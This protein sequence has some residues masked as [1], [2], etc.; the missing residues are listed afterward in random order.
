MV[1]QINRA[2]II[3]KIKNT[4]AKDAARYIAKSLHEKKI[5][6]FSLE[7]LDV[8]NIY[9][10]EPAELMNTD[11][12]LVFGTTLRAFRMVRKS[13]PVF[14][15][16][17]GGTRGIL[18]EANTKPIEQQLHDIFNENY[19][20]DKRLR[21]QAHVDGK[22]IG[23]AL[24]DVVITRTNLTK[25]PIFTINVFDYPVSQ[26]MDGVI[27]STPTGSTGH[28]L[29]LGGPIVHENMNCVMILP[30]APVNKT[31]ALI[32]ELEDIVISSTDSSKIIIDGQQVFD[33]R[34]KNNITISKYPY[35]GVFL[36]IG[37]R[38]VRQIEKLGF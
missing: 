12:D 21:I 36:R 28:A 35:D 25:T 23:A 19:F 27:I 37:K 13:T 5:K 10:V 29:S 22:M 34:S 3:T 31:P 20:Y 9:Q 11:L 17:I 18:A 8:N 1:L 6:V 26:K 32:L 15:L 30:I 33:S 14:S 4:L 2:A 7:P 16:N 38:G 24:N